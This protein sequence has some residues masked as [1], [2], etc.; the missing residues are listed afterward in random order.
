MLKY[1]IKLWTIDKDLFGEAVELF[2][3]K[4]I[5]FVELYIVPDRVELKELGALKEI[6]VAVHCPHFKHDFNVFSLDDNKIKLFREQ[7]VKA[8]DFLE[9]EHI[10]VHAGIGESP[11]VFKQNS[12]KI[13]DKRV[14]I[15]NMPGIALNDELC[16]GYSLK[17]L[18]FIH[19]E[20]GFDICFDFAHAVK[21][22]MYQKIDE[23]NFVESLIS[24]LNPIYFHIAGANRDSIK[25]EHINLFQSDVNIKPI[26]EILMRLSKERDLPLVFE[27]PKT[28]GLE[29]D[30]ENIRYFRERI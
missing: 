5:D 1:G 25:D 10:I 27:A 23:M 18:Q 7:V 14:I 12:C 26:K 21:S 15:E 16:F 4:E 6:P 30:I 19:K 24:S 22:A 29:N 9:S 17:Q 3:S 13:Y 8:A 20:C 28:K 2:R 11:D